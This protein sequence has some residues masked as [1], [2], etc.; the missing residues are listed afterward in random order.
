M[1]Q[2]ILEQWKMAADLH[3]NED[4]LT[5]QRFSYFVTLTGLLIS[6]LGLVISQNAGE[7]ETEEFAFLVS[8]FGIIVS[9]IFVC[10]FSR[11]RFYQ[12]YRIAQARTLE[13]E[14]WGDSKPTLLIYE[15]DGIETF[16]EQDRR[17]GLK[18]FLFQKSGSHSTHE[19]IIFL[20]LFVTI[21]WCAIGGYCVYLRI[22]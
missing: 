2:K 5:W 19:L 4:K 22:S 16:I 9:G 6:G 8:F 20:S 13:A 21:V 15:K 14:Y 7:S 10:I 11:S 3:K 17:V 12:R 1:E 18:N